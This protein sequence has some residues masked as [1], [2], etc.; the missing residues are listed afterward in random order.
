MHGKRISPHL[1]RPHFTELSLKGKAS[2]QNWKQALKSPFAVLTSEIET[3]GRRFHQ[4][5]TARV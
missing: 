4:A 1:P 3:D 5:L 2:F